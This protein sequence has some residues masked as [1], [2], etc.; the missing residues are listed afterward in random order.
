MYVK[1]TANDNAMMITCITT[2]SMNARACCTSPAGASRWVR[3]QLAVACT[4]NTYAVTGSVS[5]M[6][7]SGA[8]VREGLRLPTNTVISAGKRVMGWPLREERC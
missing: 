7:G 2:A 6:S 8:V 1:Y 5:G 3:L 4:T